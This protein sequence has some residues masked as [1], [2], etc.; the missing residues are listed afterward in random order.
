MISDRC[1]YNTGLKDARGLPIYEGD[2]VLY[3]LQG[4]HTKREYWNPEYIVEWKPP[5]FQLKWIGGGKGA[6]DSDFKLR[7]GGANGDLYIT[8]RGYYHMKYE[9][10]IADDL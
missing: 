4:T 6:G 10:G 5:S 9:L 3:K 7:C 8:S 1:A 2:T